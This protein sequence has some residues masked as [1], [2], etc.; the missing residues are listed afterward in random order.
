M[1]ILPVPRQNHC[2]AT[3]LTVH[4]LNSQTK[5]KKIVISPRTNTPYPH[6]WNKKIGKRFAKK[7]KTIWTRLKQDLKHN[8]KKHE[9]SYMYILNTPKKKQ[10][11]RHTSDSEKQ[12][13]KKELTEE[14]GD[15]LR[16]KCPAARSGETVHPKKSRPKTGVFELWFLVLMYL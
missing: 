10:K 4:H 14:L 5:Q 16:W 1:E 11:K 15:G 12:K 2:C 3:F 8:L 7:W 9:K 6:P 13:Q